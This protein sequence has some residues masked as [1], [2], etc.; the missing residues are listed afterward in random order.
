MSGREENCGNINLSTYTMTL[1]SI[2]PVI[3]AARAVA[4]CMCG[5]VSKV[6]QCQACTYSHSSNDQDV[7]ELAVICAR[8]SS[9]VDNIQN[10]SSN[11]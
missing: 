6:K 2:R 7:A 8:A 1:Y 3:A 11:E 5:V 4:L 10:K 9:F